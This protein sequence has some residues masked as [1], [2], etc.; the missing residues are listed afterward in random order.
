Y[1]DTLNLNS[2]VAF[3]ES[4]PAE[5]RR[6]IEITVTELG[7]WHLPGSKERWSPN[8]L[9][10][11][12]YQFRWLGLIQTN[13]KGMVRTPLFW[14]TR[15]LDAIKKGA[16]EK[17]FHALNMAGELAPSGWAIRI[18]NEF[19]HDSLV[20]VTLPC[21]A[22]DVYCYASQKLGDPDRL[23]VW[24]VNNRKESRNVSL[25]LKHY[26][27]SRI[28]AMYRY[29]GKGPDD[30]YPV[31]APLERPPGFKRNAPPSVD[32]TLRPYSITVFRFDGGGPGS[33]DRRAR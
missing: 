4:L 23:T 19:V 17:S 21:A 3:L 27:G 24:L 15:W 13:G 33:D 20:K 32:C 18:W 30:K 5:D 2:A 1:R 9:R 28:A 26:T 16:Y 8:D 12:L 31:I 10:R 22:R 11:S 14:T 25:K 6:R 7:T 29:A